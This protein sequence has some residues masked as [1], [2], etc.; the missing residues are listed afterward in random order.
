MLSPI[1]TT[2]SAVANQLAQRAVLEITQLGS[3]LAGLLDHGM[4][5]QAAVAAQTAPNGQVMPARA[6]VPAVSPEAFAAALGTANVAVLTTV[7]ASLG[8]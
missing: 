7:R 2:E 8:L 5:S 6:A 4:P 3:R 1:A